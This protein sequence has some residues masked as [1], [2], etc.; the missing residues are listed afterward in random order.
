[1]LVKEALSN[2]VILGNFVSVGIRDV[3][4]RHTKQLMLQL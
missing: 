3:V 1:M 2:D 4:I